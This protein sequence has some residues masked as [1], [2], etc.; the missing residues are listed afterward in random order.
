MGISRITTGFI[1]EIK[2]T[3]KTKL[4]TDSTHV[5]VGTNNSTP[6]ASNTALGN[7]VLR[8]S[9]QEYTELPNSV[10]LSGYFN[11]AEANSNTLTE[12]GFFDASSGGNL[13]IR[14]LISPLAKTIDK[15]LWVDN[16]TKFIV[17]QE[18]G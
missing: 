14:F 15:E 4:I 3:A 7:E 10:I 16:E 2:E 13:I 11:S 17:I 12:S 9:R 18:S 1:T 6:Q 5:A 8:K